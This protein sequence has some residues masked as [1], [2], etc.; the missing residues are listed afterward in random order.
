VQSGFST[1]IAAAIRAEC[2]TV[3]G[4][5]LDVP[6]RL[7]SAGARAARQAES[8]QR[9]YDSGCSPCE[10]WWNSPTAIVAHLTTTQ[11]TLGFIG[12]V[13]FL[14]AR[15]GIVA[16]RSQHEETESYDNLLLQD[17]SPIVE[18]FS[19]Q[20]G[21]RVF[22]GT[23]PFL[24]HCIHRLHNLLTTEPIDDLASRIFCMGQNAGLTPH[25]FAA[26]IADVP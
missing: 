24:A 6:S 11:L 9:Q 13:D 19:V 2:R 15:H 17:L 8:S 23:R 12:P 10:L 25:S 4:H 1:E 7:L 22:L 5:S 16:E 21:D 3:R 20:S 14:L 18:S 26:I